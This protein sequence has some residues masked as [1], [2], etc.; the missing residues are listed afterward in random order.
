[1][2]CILLP[3]PRSLGSGNAGGESVEV[4][5]SKCERMRLPFD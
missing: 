3:L 1:M 2:T 4:V 5:E